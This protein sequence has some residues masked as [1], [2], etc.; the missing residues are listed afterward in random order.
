MSAKHAKN[1][2]V[3]LYERL[4]KVDAPE[5]LEDLNPGSLHILKNA[6]VEPAVISEKPDVRFQFERQGYFYADPVDYTDAKPV[7]N[8]L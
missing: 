4:Y 6:Y 8:K 7:F 5:G 2:E 3:R 1:V